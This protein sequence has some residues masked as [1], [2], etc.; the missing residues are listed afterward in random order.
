M[1]YIWLAFQWNK[2]YFLVIPQTRWDILA[3]LI[4]ISFGHTA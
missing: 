4:I 2:N 3:Y 1:I